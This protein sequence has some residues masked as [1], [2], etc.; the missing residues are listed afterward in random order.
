MRQNDS[1][2]NKAKELTGFF[3]KLVLNLKYI[4]TFN[5]DHILPF[6]VNKVFGYVELRKAEGYIFK[7]IYYLY[8]FF[9]LSFVYLILKRKKKKSVMFVIDHNHLR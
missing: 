3:S 5:T 7:K 8:Y 1:H 6:P 4:T 9:S 2:V